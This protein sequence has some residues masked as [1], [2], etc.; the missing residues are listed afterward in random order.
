[1]GFFDALKK[2]IEMTDEAL[3]KAATRMTDEQLKAAQNK[4][5]KYIKEEMRKRGLI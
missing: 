3:K 1:M 5:S 4:D 2:G